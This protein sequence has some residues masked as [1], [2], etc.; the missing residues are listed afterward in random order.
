MPNPAASISSTAHPYRVVEVITPP[1]FLMA[2]MRGH[3]R[4]IVAGIF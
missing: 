3:R 1:A 2:T 4:E